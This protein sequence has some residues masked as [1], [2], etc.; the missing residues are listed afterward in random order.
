MA[1]SAAA[2]AVPR[3]ALVE[4]TAVIQAQVAQAAA[5]QQQQRMS[6]LMGQQQQGGQQQQAQQALMFLQAQQRM[7]GM[8]PPDNITHQQ[9]MF[10]SIPPYT[11]LPPINISPDKHNTVSLPI[12]C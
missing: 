2:S 4:Q 8:R 1:A 5:Q 3:Q 6:M 12:I 11:P 10:V 9:R 7:T